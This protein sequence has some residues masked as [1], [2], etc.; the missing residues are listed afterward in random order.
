MESQ[1]SV[2]RGRGVPKPAK[3]Q[4]TDDIVPGRYLIEITFARMGEYLFRD[5]R[6]D[7]GG[8]AVP[9]HPLNVQAYHGAR[10]LIAGPNFGC[11]SSR[12]HA[13]QALKRY[14]IDLIIAPSLAE[15]FA[16]NSASIGLVA[17]TASESDVGALVDFV[18]KQPGTEIVMNLETKTATYAG[19]AIRIDLPEGRR[20]AF[21]TGTW[22][23]MA[24]LQRNDAG[25]RRVEQSLPYLNF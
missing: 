9:S 7:K 16:G 4:N 24:V 21:L 8:N 23:R 1:I 14:G 13:P 3:D 22:D 2:I 25:I 12:E 10:I 20:Q 18:T 17:V 6:F 5:E 19:R 11:G 15:I